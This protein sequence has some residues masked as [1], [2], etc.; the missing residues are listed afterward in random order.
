VK[1]EVLVGAYITYGIREKEQQTER[2]RK[3]HQQTNKK[4]HNTALLLI[5]QEINQNIKNKA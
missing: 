1:L 4:L 2:Q 3:I 5:H